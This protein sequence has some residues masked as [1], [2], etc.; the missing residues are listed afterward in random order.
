MKTFQEYYKSKIN[1][2]EFLDQSERME[3][4]CDNLAND[5]L[6]AEK[7]GD[8]ATMTKIKEQIFA[9]GDY[10]KQSLDSKIRIARFKSKYPNKTLLSKEAE[11]DPIFDDEYDPFH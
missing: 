10:C 5:Y 11:T 8:K 7:T 2:N 6:H 3:K 1:E 9:L 4:M